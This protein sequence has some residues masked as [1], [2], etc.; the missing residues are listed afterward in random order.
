M[1]K[2]L[3]SAIE[4][5]ENFMQK[6]YNLNNIMPLYIR[7]SSKIIKNIVLEFDGKVKL[8]AGREVLR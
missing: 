5:F 4:R 6:T 1:F 7:I 8:A 3:K 2:L